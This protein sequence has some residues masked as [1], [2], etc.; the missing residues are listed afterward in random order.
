ML[1]ETLPQGRVG[2][3]YMEYDNTKYFVKLLLQGKHV[4][5]N[6]RQNLGHVQKY[7]QCQEIKRKFLSNISR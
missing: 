4:G 6:D 5:Q 3:V 1:E 2:T 7:K